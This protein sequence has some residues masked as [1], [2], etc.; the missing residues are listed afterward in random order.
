MMA[1]FV[2]GMSGGM[3]AIVWVIGGYWAPHAL[4]AVALMV[5]EG[6]VLLS[7]SLLGGTCLTTLANGVVVFMLFGLAFAAGW[8]EQIGALLK[9][10]TLSS[11]GIVISFVIPSESMWRRAAYLMQPPFLRQLAFGP[12]ATATAPSGVMVAYACAYVGI[13]FGLAIRFFNKRDL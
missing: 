4:D 11:I 9:N 7:L 1:I 8:I 13:A 6:L 5:L 12:F 3:M 10:D 2:L